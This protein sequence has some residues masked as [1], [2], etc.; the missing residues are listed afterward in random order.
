MVHT[1]TSRRHKT[2]AIQAFLPSSQHTTRTDALVNGHSFCSASTDA[3]RCMLSIDT[4][5]RYLHS[6]RIK[7]RWIQGKKL[8]FCK[9]VEL[10]ARTCFRSSPKQT[11][12]EGGR[13]KNSVESPTLFFRMQLGGRFFPDRTGNPVFFCESQSFVRHQPFLDE[14]TIRGNVSCRVTSDASK[15]M[16]GYHCARTEKSFTMSVCQKNHV[17]LLLLFFVR[18]PCMLSS[19]SPCFVRR[20][21]LFASV[22][23]ERSY[24]VLFFF[25][26]NSPPPITGIE[27]RDQRTLQESR[28]NLLFPR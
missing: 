27:S 6:R 17:N 21:C 26:L 13:K 5:K 24:C 4:S 1:H 19:A 14:Q 11:W 12:G 20:A 15:C 7:S 2:C 25:A 28:I 22:A 8:L 18:A 10:V 3:R 16:N 9:K 23:I